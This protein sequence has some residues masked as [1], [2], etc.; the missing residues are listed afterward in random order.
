MQDQE[1]RKKEV[2]VERVHP[3]SSTTISPHIH[4]ENE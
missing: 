2:R 3:I 1:R 4:L